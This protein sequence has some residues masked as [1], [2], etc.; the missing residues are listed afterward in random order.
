MK[1]VDLE[2]VLAIKEL[3]WRIL[4][5]VENELDVLK[6]NY[7]EMEKS[8]EDMKERLKAGVMDDIGGCQR[9]VAHK[10]AKI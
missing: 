2:V 4:R 10:Y 1:Q 6:K 3:N 5:K 9:K 8:L 7:P